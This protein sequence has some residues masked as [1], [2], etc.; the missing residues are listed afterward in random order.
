VFGESL[1][2]VEGDPVTLH[3]G[4]KTD[5]QEKIRWYFNSGRIA[6]INGDLSFMC[7]DVQCEEADER[8]RD[9][10]QLDHQTGSLTI[11]NTRT[12][13]SGL[14]KLKIISSSSFSEKICNVTIH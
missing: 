8:F 3:T 10:L 9:R 1:S 13:D 11:M 5:Q 4:V 12:T 14:Y 7:T 2:A 6:Q